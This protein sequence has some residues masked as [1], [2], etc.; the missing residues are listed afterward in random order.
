MKYPYIR[1][2]TKD[3]LIFAKKI[4]HFLG[5]ARAFFKIIVVGD[6]L[7]TCRLVCATIDTNPCIGLKIFE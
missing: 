4:Y 6:N 3:I 7:N 5:T 2:Q 1:C